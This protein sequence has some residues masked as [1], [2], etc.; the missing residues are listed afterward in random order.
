MATAMA[1]ASLALR[2]TRTVIPMVGGTSGQEI[3]NQEKGEGKSNGKG[4]DDVEADSDF[5][6]LH[7]LH[8][9]AAIDL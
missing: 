8:S 7:I 4:V 9:I 3:S 2:T 5:V 1:T 6:L